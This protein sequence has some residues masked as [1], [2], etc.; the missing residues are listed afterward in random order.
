M[1]TKEGKDF[2]K[3]VVN[4]VK[5]LNKTEEDQATESELSLTTHSYYVS[6]LISR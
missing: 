3:R 5:S 1:K 4:S 6:K 2:R